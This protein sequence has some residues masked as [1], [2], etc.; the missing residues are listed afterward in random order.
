M[1]RHSELDA[2]RMVDNGTMKFKGEE[3]TIRWYESKLTEDDVDGDDHRRVLVTGLPSNVDAEAIQMFF[4]SK[5]QDGGPVED[6][7]Y[8]ISEGQAV[9]TFEESS[10]ELLLLLLLTFI[11]FSL[12]FCYRNQSAIWRISTAQVYPKLL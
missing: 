9:I 6:V 11:L 5:R 8:E 2:Q 1:K 12:Y 4:E 3:M 7:K 10:G